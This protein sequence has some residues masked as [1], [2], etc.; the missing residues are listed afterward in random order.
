[1][2]DEA[3]RSQHRGPATQ[4]TVADLLARHGRGLGD[5]TTRRIPRRHARPDESD[6]VVLDSRPLHARRSPLRPVGHDLA[7][8]PVER[9]LVGHHPLAASPVQASPVQ[10]SPVQASPVQDG[11][12]EASTVS[13]RPVRPESD[14]PAAASSTRPVESAD[15][16]DDQ[17]LYVGELLSREGRGGRTDRNAF[18]LSRVLAMAAGAVVLC[19]AV[20]FSAT[21]LMGTSESQQ[22]PASVQFDARMVDGAIA[23][24]EVCIRDRNTLDAAT[25]ASTAGTAPTSNS[26][27]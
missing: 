8:A 25:D 15:R 5:A 27:R 20:G 22:P 18:T 14:V 17:E 21:Q 1:M 12:A 26:H 6:T 4:V 10:T 9:R 19:G 11:P 13:F 3:N 7:P 2:L 23:P 24:D 16:D